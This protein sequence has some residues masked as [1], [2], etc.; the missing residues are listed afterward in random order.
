M[1]HN[2]QPHR[3]KNEYTPVPAKGSD[4]VMIF[5]AD[6]IWMLE[7]NNQLTLPTVDEI[8]ATD[9][10]SLRYLFALE[11]HRYYRL[12]DD[13]FTPQNPNGSYIKVRSLRH[14]LFPKQTD[15]ILSAGSLSSSEQ[16]MLFHQKELCFAI[17]TGW[18]LHT[19]YRDHAFCGRCG[20]PT[21]HSD[22]QRMLQCPNCKNMIFPTIAPAV[23]IGVVNGDHILL[24][25]YSDRDYIGYALL[26][27]FME[28]S[29]TPEDTVKREVM[30]E[31]HLQ[32]KNIRYYKS[33]PGGI[34]GNVLLGFF[35]DLDGDDAIQIDESELAMAKWYHRDEIPV[36]NDG[37]SLTFEM[38]SYFHD[39]PEKFKDLSD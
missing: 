11:S 27:G 37:Y 36:K 17:M 28:I 18:H 31:V 33:Q 8:E 19:W 38:I 35:C 39:H 15:H 6:Q 29:E 7:H 24:S 13:N 30:E 23:I 9:A 4:L 5:Q 25:K 2:I 20:T 22:T 1:I 21:V 12:E 26:A 3:L 32:V 14:R 34:D 10:T 16:T